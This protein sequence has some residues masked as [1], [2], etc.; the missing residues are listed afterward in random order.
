MLVLDGVKVLGGGP[1]TQTQ[2]VLEVPLSPRAQG[3]PAI[4]FHDKIWSR[5]GQNLRQTAPVRM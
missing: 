3:D 2:N 5:A 4:K 1:H